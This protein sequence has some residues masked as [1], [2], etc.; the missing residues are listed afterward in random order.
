LNNSLKQ[1]DTLSVFLLFLHSL[2]S[3]PV[4]I[5]TLHFSIFLIVWVFFCL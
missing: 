3:L 5:T 4:I 2:W 1:S